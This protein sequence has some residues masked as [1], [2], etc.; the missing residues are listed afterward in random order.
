[1]PYSN[2]APSPALLRP[3]TLATAT[4]EECAASTAASTVLDS[5]NT[6]QG[7]T[8]D[9]DSEA[10]APV[11]GHVSAAQARYRRRREAAR[12]QQDVELNEAATAQ[13]A[14]NLQEAVDQHVVDSHGQAASVQVK[15]L[16][17][18]LNETA[19]EISSA[20]LKQ[21]SDR[22]RG[23]FHG[24][25][26]THAAAFEKTNTDYMSDEDG[27][28]VLFV[29][30]K[31]VHHFELGIIEQMG[32]AA[33][34][35]TSKGKRARPVSQL[36]INDPAGVVRCRWFDQAAGGVQLYTLPL[37]QHQ[38]FNWLIPTSQILAIVHVPWS[39]A[40]NAYSLDASDAQLLQDEVD[41]ANQEQQQQQKQPGQKRKR[42]ANAIENMDSDEEQAARA[43][44]ARSK[45]R[46]PGTQGHSTSR[47]VSQQAASSES[48]EDERPVPAICALQRREAGTLPLG[49][50]KPA[51]PDAS[52]R[53]SG[54]IGQS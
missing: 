5:S 26:L 13:L 15:A 12:V 11:A 39:V 37:K 54:R 42:T 24:A 46:R 28:G 51:K 40:R 1:M 21:S 31:G 35:S 32:K 45:R 41:K 8:S 17:K 18:M 34:S 52:G 43:T 33:R 14:A 49:R 36:S 20:F 53:R 27:I 47:G 3:P 9:D 44:A 25:Q 4:D 23:R 30:D 38:H 6:Q 7:A 22:T 2:D 50:R 29:D 10:C 16:Y 48:S 19:R